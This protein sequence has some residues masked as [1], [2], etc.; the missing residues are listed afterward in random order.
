MGRVRYL[1]MHDDANRRPDYITDL[2]FAFKDVPMSSSDFTKLGE[3][4]G[5]PLF[6]QHKVYMDRRPYFSDDELN[7]RLKEIKPLPPAFYEFGLPE[8]YA[9]AKRKHVLKRAEDKQKQQVKDKS[10]YTITTE[11]VNRIIALANATVYKHAILH[12]YEPLTNSN[13]Y[14]D[15]FVSIQLMCGRR[16]FE[17]GKTLRYM[18]GPTEY[19]ARVSGICKNDH[20]GEDWINIPILCKYEWFKAAMDKLRAFNDYSV[21]DVI[22]FS[23]AVSSKQA[24]ADMRVYSR[25][26]VHTQKRNLYSELA[27]SQREQ[28]RFLVGEESV[29]KNVWIGMALGHRLNFHNISTTASYQVMNIV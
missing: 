25:R 20:G 18:P 15:L 21:C 23:A 1:I 17:I 13:D 2:K 6:K 14:F 5:M 4:M 26:L 9:A 29:A 27:W 16:A 3:L 28:S 11:E 12:A 22:Q 24:P 7:K 10:F 19:Q 8:E